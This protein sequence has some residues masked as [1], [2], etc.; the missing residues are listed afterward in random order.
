MKIGTRKWRRPSPKVYRGGNTT[1]E[2]SEVTE[3]AEGWSIFL[4]RF[5]CMSVP[6]FM[7]L[8]ARI[9]DERQL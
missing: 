2:D 1:H 3:T 6:T 5:G 8:A 9:G 4:K 7:T